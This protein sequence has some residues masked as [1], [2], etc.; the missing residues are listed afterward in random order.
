MQWILCYTNL[1][2][3]LSVGSWG[4]GG[5]VSLKEV[6]YHIATYPD[7]TSIPTSAR[8]SEWK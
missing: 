1:I 3:I 7:P 6:S 2:D 4:V 5:G 8:E